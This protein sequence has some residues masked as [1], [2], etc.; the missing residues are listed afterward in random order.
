MPLTKVLGLA[1]AFLLALPCMAAPPAL[2]TKQDARA[3]TESVMKL[4]AVDKIDDAFQVL[5]PYWHLGPGELETSVM[6]TVSLRN[7]IADRFGPTT[8]YAFVRE[9][10]LGDFLLRYI[11]V[12]KRKNHPLRWTFI[13]YRGESDW[14]VDAASWDDNVTQLFPQ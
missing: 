9:D 13:F 5:K 8:G 14:A 10:A 4:V 7:T 2:Q 12:E 3:L 1:F 11:Y 6:K